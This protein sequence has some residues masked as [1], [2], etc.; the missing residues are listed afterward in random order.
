MVP[1]IANNTMILKEAQKVGLPII[2]LVNSHCH[3][4][5]DYPIFAQDQTLQSIH[6]FCHFLAVLI[7]KESFFL[8]HKRYTL[9]KAFSK[10]I[11]NQREKIKESQKGFSKNKK[12]FLDKIL[13]PQK[14]KE[15][16][17]RIFFFKIIK[18]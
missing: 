3:T 16:S 13:V 18:P 5:I 10:K 17:N 9:Q 4:E 12:I 15:F 7:A 14:K 6:F 1:D 8:E 2:G 11:F